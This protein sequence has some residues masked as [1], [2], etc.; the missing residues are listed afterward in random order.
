MSLS[1]VCYRKRTARNEPKPTAGVLGA[2]ACRSCVR[3]A[4]AAMI[5]RPP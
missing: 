2:W 1:W 5:E 4:L 3:V